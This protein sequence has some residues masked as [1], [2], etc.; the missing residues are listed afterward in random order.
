MKKLLII[1]LL[2][3]LWAIA[4][5][6]PAKTIQGSW[7]LID[8]KTSDESINGLMQFDKKQLNAMRLTFDAGKVCTTS[9]KEKTCGDYTLKGRILT[10][11]GLAFKE[12]IMSDKAT[13]EADFASDTL[14]VTVPVE[15]TRQIMAASVKEYARRGG[16]AFLIKMMESAVASAEVKGII[17]LK[18]Q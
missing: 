6:P 2:L 15:L 17:M 8:V 1:V 4:Q 3:P 13:L 10:V 14:T 5:S 9:G 7:K 12:F 18:R 11:S 16:D